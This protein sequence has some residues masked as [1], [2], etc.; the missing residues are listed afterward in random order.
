MQRSLQQ[1]GSVT[2]CLLCPDVAASGAASA[3][4]PLRATATAA[5]TA[6]S[7]CR[8]VP[9]LVLLIGRIGAALIAISAAVP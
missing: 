1:H 2:V 4:E 5:A 7:I 3:G 9:V 6:V 8:G